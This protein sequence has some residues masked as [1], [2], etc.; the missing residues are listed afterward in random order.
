METTRLKVTGMSCGGC[1]SAVT[2]ALQEV[3]GVQ[4][5]KV[6]L[7][8]GAATVQHD[9]NTQTATLVEAVTDAGFEA[10]TNASQS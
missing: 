9:A 4:D 10:Q 1:V 2:S 3:A 6:D 7:A 8:S 5:V